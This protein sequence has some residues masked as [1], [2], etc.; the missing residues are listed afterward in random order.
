MLVSAYGARW[1]EVYLSFFTAYIDDS[2]TDPS[3][4]VANATAIIVPASRIVMFQ[5]EWDK[6]RAKEG[7]SV[8]HTSEFAAREKNPKS[9]F[10][11]WDDDKHDRVF[12]RVRQ[13]C[14]KYSVNAMSFSV[15]KKDY[16]EIVPE[17]MRKDSGLFHYTWA[18]RHMLS[19]LT[20][21]RIK[22]GAMPLE[23][24]FSWMGEKR[25]NKR[26][27]EIEDVMDQA[28]EDCPGEFKNW[29]FRDHTEIPGLQC[30]DALA[31]CVYQAGL[32]T[33]CGKPLV[34][35][36]ELAWDH[37]C[38]HQGG[39]WGYDV[40]VTRESL[41]KWVDKEMADGTSLNKFKA[42]R[43]RKGRNGQQAGVG[44][45]P[46]LRP[47]NAATDEGATRDNTSQVGSGEKSESEK[48]ES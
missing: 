48:A 37:F 25:K 26:R 22:H 18:I 14:L 29:S 11:D 44:G 39:R 19:H 35:D 23:Y 21:W 41:Q 32:R 31:W 28:E 20:A 3:Q 42:W 46:K 47:H 16:D 40:T 30:V 24:I 9:E 1:K 5:R 45:V 12:T 13:I 43:E 36:A 27:Q 34:R 33:F 38:A 4:P 2:G 8:W 17:I 10:C 6:L 7:F 15:Y